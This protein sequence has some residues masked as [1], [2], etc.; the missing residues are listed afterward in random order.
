MQ[1]SWIHA[2]EFR[3]Y[4]TLDWTPAPRLNLL[5]GPNAQG[6]TNLLEALGMLLVGRSFRTPRIAEL[7]RWG[8]ESS[9]LTGELVRGDAENAAR[10]TVRRALTKLEE[11]SWESAGESVEW[12]RAIAFGWQDLEIVNGGPG[13]RRNFIDGS[14]GRL[15]PTHLATLVRFRQV[16]ARR[17]RLLQQRQGDVAAR[18]EPWNEQLAVVGMELIERRRKAVAALQTELARVY[19]ALSTTQSKVEVRYR[20]SLGESSEPA[21]LLAALQRFQRQELRRGQTLVGPHRD[22][23]AIEIDG[24]DARAFGSRG[25]QRLVALALRLAEVL[26]VTEAAGTAPVLLLD[27]ALSELDPQ[28]REHVLRELGSAE[29]IF[30]TTP[31][32]LA[33][34]GAAV[35]HVNAGGIAAA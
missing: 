14:A 22:D 3:N 16:L 29:Q 25:Q 15:Y 6:K 19:R 12:A 24:V 10:R 30:L 20:T 4:R 27:D 2:A 33:M 34:S 1:I 11:G 7:P 13:A 35:F 17:N 18:L 5:T 28:V 26:P 31:E 9:L 23:L 21:A 8:A 32:P